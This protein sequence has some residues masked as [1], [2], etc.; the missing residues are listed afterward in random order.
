MIRRVSKFVSVVRGR[1]YIVAPTTDPNSYVLGEPCVSTYHFLHFFFRGGPEPEI[2]YQV[3][4]TLDPSG[5]VPNYL[6]CFLPQEWEGRR[7][8]RKVEPCT[9]I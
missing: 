8:R 2:S 1:K 7:I 5:V 3:T 6:P 4:Y 9:R